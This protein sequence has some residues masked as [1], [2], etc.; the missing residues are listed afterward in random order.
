MQWDVFDAS[1][2][3]IYTTQTDKAL[4]RI[5]EYTNRGVSIFYVFVEPHNKQ[6]GSLDILYDLETA[7]NFGLN[8]ASKY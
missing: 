6:L 7:K 5:K 1:A 4:V 2:C 3:M 8:K